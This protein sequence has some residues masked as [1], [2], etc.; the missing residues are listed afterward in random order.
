MRD[1]YEV[2]REKERA[3]QRIEREIKVL[4]MAAP[5]LTD[6]TDVRPV[7]EAMPDGLQEANGPLPTER[8]PDTNDAGESS[9]EATDDVKIGAAKRISTRLKRMATP[10][11]NVSRAAS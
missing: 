4:R 8:A 7:A 3:I 6:D 10:L 5:L 1:V 11:L 9:T 2:L